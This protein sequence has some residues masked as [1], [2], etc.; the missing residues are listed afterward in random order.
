MTQRDEPPIPVLFGSTG[1]VV[2]LDFDDAS[3]Y[4]AGAVG[5]EVHVAQILRKSGIAVSCR[6]TRNIISDLPDRE[7]RHLPHSAATREITRQGSCPEQL[8]CTPEQRKLYTRRSRPRRFVC[9]PRHHVRSTFSNASY[10]LLLISLISFQSCWDVQAATK[11]WVI[12]RTPKDHLTCVESIMML[13]FSYP[14][15]VLVEALAL[16]RQTNDTS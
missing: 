13:T 10:I 11:L 1:D 12:N 16:S 4:L 3:Q 6:I 8:G 9:L 7:V 2:D 5:P 14:I 15:Y